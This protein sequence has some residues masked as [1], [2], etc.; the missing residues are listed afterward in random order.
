MG[1]EGAHRE[2]AFV[3]DILVGFALGLVRLR[4]VSLLYKSD[5]S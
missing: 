3:L 5:F 2:E 1:A 4:M